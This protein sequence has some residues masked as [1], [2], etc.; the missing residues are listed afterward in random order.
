MSAD[1]PPSHEKKY[2]AFISYSSKDRKWGKWLHSRLEN[3]PIPKEFQGTELFDGAVLGKDLKPCFRDRDELSGS[4]DLG[5]AIMN[6]LNQSRYLIVLC[7]KNSAKSEWVNKEIEDF[8]DIG[9]EKK[10]LALILDGEPNAT[11]N[12]NLPDEEECFPPALRYPCEPLAGDMRKE[13]D[14]KERGFLKVLSGIAQLDFD[15][16]YRRHERA[17]RKKR[18]VLGGASI[19]L[20]TT[21]TLLSI[22]AVSQKIKADKETARAEIQT[23]KV[24][25]A[26][27]NQDKLLLEASMGDHEAAT[28]AFNEGRYNEGLAYLDRSIRLKPDNVGP[29]IMAANYLFGPASPNHVTR[30]IAS[31]DDWVTNITFNPNGNLIAISHGGSLTL[32]EAGTGNEIYSLKFGDFVTPVAFSPDGRWLAVGSDDSIVRVIETATGKEV[33]S[34]EFGGGVNCVVFSPDGRWFAAGSGDHTARVIEAATGKEISSLKFQ[35]A[36]TSVTFSPDGRRFAA[37]SNDNTARLIEAATGK[38]L[39]SLEFGKGVFSVVF[40]PD[41][42]LL[43]A[44]SYSE[45][46]RLMETATGMEVSSLELGVGV[47]SLIFSPDGRWLARGHPDNRVR[48]VEVATDKDVSVLKFEER[49]ISKVFSPDGQWLAV[50]CRDNIARVME[51]ATGTQVSSVEFGDDVESVVFSPDGHWLAAGSRDNTV[52]VI[53]SATGKNVYSL[54]FGTIV[55]SVAFSPDGRWLAVG[56][57]DN[58]AHML[59]SATGKEEY[60]LDFGAIVTSVAFSPDGRWLAVGSENNTA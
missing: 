6:A 1:L 4:A 15:V 2:W 45:I 58:A 52:R 13:G 30:W 5:P 46:S 44:E 11:S 26:N 42:S 38:Q 23:R 10:I 40:S 24:E 3:Y 57:W 18:L 59:E 32:K 29:Q 19:A 28:R 54:E 34:L 22:A 47:N 55:T 36:V 60:S 37:G 53:E 33:S 51:V 9:G 12:S 21:L 31:F 27:A 41:G 49:V 39:S 43:I 8:K 35:E 20:I 14:G 17:Q 48:V 25:E 7:S 56:C 16:L 50:G